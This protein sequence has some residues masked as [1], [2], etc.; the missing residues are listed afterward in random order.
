M[1]RR[2]ILF[3]YSVPLI[4]C[5]TITTGTH[6]SIVISS[7]PS[8]ANA[9]LVCNSKPAGGGP[10]PLTITIRRNAGDCNLR[11][12]KDGFEEATVSIE[13][14]VNPAYW[15]NMVFTPLGP[16]GSYLLVEGNSGEKV[17]GL[18]ALGT[19]FVLLATDFWTGAVHAH[20]PS[21]I[22][23]VLKPKQ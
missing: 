9:T 7:S 14:G 21:R 18:A 17:I 13:Q 12:A 19:G 20:R 8:A 2:F 10:T 15:T 1:W 5:A 4:S 3:L 11:I 16:G 22:D 23:V 6:E